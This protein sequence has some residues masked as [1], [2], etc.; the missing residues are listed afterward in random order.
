MHNTHPYLHQCDTKAAPP[1]TDD[2]LQSVQENASQIT[3]KSVS[4]YANHLNQHLLRCKF[5]HIE[6]RINH[7]MQDLHR[8][9]WQCH[10]FLGWTIQYLM[11]P[12]KHLKFYLA[13]V[14]LPEMHC[15]ALALL[16]HPLTDLPPKTALN[17]LLIPHDNPTAYL[18]VLVLE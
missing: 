4:Q 1:H 7:L 11:T 12:P 18:V 6:A 17:L 15:H 10:E 5:Y 8:S 16:I 9:Q 3:H 2:P 14:K 13:V